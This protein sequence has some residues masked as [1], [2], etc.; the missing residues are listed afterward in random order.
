MCD[1]FQEPH[2]LWEYPCTPM[3]EVHRI[4]SFNYEEKAKSNKPFCLTEACVKMPIKF[5]G[6]LN[7][8]A[9]WHSIEYECDDDRESKENRFSLNT[10][11]LNSPVQDQPLEWCINHKQTVHLMD[12]SNI[13]NEAEKNFVN[14]NCSIKFEPHQAKFN[15]DFIVNNLNNK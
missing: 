15:V 14:L 10:G 1:G 12:S 13:I 3:S 2:S 9:L 5:T 8:C 4:F 6:C 7:A 11:L